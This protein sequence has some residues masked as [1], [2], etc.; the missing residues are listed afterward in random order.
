MATFINTYT[1]T[2][3]E[4]GRI[5]LPSE[6]KK[7]VVEMGLEKVVLEKNHQKKSIDI[8]PEKTWVE[9]V[10]KLK[11]KLNTHNK[12]HALFLQKYFKNFFRVNIATSG[13][14]NIPKDF[15]EFANLKKS[16]DFIGMSDSISMIAS[17]NP[18]QAEMSDEEYDAIWDELGKK[19]D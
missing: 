14:I 4:K 2:V 6:F 12:Q 5:V 11:R 19:E 7:A 18:V 15:L 1:G 16:V 13:R 10:E 3:D 8:H 17:T 9:N